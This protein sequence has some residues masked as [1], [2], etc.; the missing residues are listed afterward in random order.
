MEQLPE[1]KTGEALPQL[2]T[3][4]EVALAVKV[5]ESTVVTWARTGKIDAVVLPSGH[6]RFKR[7]VIDA[8]LAGQAAA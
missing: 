1:Q 3:A 5:K 7:E 4:E 2:Y 6:R 8:L